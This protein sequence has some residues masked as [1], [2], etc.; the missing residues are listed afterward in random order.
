MV[1]RRRRSPPPFWGINI[2]CRVPEPDDA[3]AIAI[4]RLGINCVRLHFMDIAAPRAYR[5]GDDT[6]NRPGPTRAPRPP[7]RRTEE[8][9]HLLNLNLNVGADGKLATVSVMRNSSASAKRH[10]FEPRLIGAEGS[11]AGC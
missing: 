1:T 4:A 11:P 6:A 3:P 7:H 10:Y 2:V 8:A 5:P 9:G